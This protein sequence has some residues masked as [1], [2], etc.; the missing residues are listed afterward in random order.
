MEKTQAS[1]YS[2]GK[3]KD[4]ELSVGLTRDVFQ[5]QAIRGLRSK[6][7]KWVSS[8]G[9]HSACIDVEGVLYICGSYLHGKLGIEDLTTT[10]VLSFTLLKALKGKQVKQVACGDFHT[11]CLLEDGS[12]YTWGGNLHKKNAKLSKGVTK[13]GIISALQG[14]YIISVGCGDFHSVALSS[15]GE[16]YSWGGGGASYNKGQCGHGHCNNSDQPTVIASLKKKE[17]IK[18]SCGGY[19]TLALTS[20]NE[21]YAF[22][23]GLFGECGFGEFSSTASPR[24][25]QFPWVKK[26]KD[27]QYG[28]IVQISGGGHHSLVLT[29]AGCVFSFGYASYGQ[30]G[31][32]STLNY[33]EPQHVNYMRAKMVKSIAAGWNHSL[34]LTGKGDVWACGYGFFGQL[35]L[36]GDES[37]TTFTH[38][39][40]LGN[41]NITKIFA[42]GNHS[43][44][45]IDIAQPIRE[46]YEPPSPIDELNISLSSDKRAELSLHQSSYMKLP[47]SDFSLTIVYSEL[48]YCHRFIN[49]T[50]KEASLEIGKARAEEYV[51]EMYVIESGVQYHRIQEDDQII[52]VKDDQGNEVVCQGGKCLFTCALIC[53]P[54]RNEPQAPWINHTKFKEVTIVKESYQ[55]ESDGTEIILSE[56]VRFF[57]SKVGNFCKGPPIFF[58]LRP[59][60]YYNEIN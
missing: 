59:Y 48:G 55:L 45:I 24:L 43:W 36:G 28:E 57:M 27:D 10:S 25:V 12:V 49:Y 11:L 54:L 46:D 18:I 19:H 23:A 9:Q 53:D 33:C 50:L 21:L 56:W 51:H 58:E 31:L 17:V 34:V 29:S 44:A 16:V 60:G 14:V 26:P 1:A 13:P 47:K 52:E 2:W 7:L 32:H 8:G 42:G 15:D 40:S 20:N 39:S 37:H 4:G 22:G 35:G 5:P 30:L 6:E 38:V 41:K 3:N